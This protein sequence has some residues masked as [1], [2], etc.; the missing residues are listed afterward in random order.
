[1]NIDKNQLALAQL[2]ILVFAAMALLSHSSLM[3]WIIAILGLALSFSLGTV[4]AIINKTH[5]RESENSEHQYSAVLGTHLGGA[6]CYAIT[7]SFTF[8]NLS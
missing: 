4:L 2:A 3:P 7:I 8:H 6:I 1:M 5:A